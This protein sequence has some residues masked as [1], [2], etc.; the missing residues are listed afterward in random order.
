[1]NKENII[2]ISNE[3]IQVVVGEMK[4]DVVR[5]LDYYH[6]PLKEG[7]MLNGVIINDIELKNVLKTLTSKGIKEVK[8][9][10]DSTKILAKPAVIPTM[11]QKEVLQFVK[12]ELS[13][14]DSNSEDLIF[15]YAFLNEDEKNKKAS[16][17]LCVGVE[18][19][20]I[21]DYLD[22][23]GDV[24]I[25]I[26]SIDYAVNVLIS[27]T[28]NLTGFI[29]K[30][31]A[32]MHVDGNNVVS[33][34]FANNDYSLTNRSRIFAN[35][36]T[37]EFET[38]IVSTVSQLKQFATSSHRDQI[39]NDIYIFGLDSDIQGHVF[40]RIRST[41]DISA[42]VLPNSKSIYA[43]KDNNE[44][45]DINNYVYPVGYLLRR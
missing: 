6:L 32:L 9:I 28:K 43:V 38:E 44:Q 13:L 24:G 17:I 20:F 18:R 16:Q 36:G 37:E 30:T 27:L 10:V 26:L 35:K 45:F 1:M 40:E 31:Y 5:V 34:L 4:R 7:T 39:M 11:K 19:K 12:D 42:K 21:K 14:I 3:D 8:L 29:D 22:A 25:E 33:V 23:F 2:Y 15:D 41:L